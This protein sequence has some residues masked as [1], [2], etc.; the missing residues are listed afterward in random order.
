MFQH[1]CEGKRQERAGK[2]EV[3]PSHTTSSHKG[4]QLFMNSFLTSTVGVKYLEYL[5]QPA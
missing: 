5:K 4:L 3:L 2:G 1:I